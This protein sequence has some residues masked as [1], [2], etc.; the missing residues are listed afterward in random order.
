MAKMSEN[1]KVTGGR[2]EGLK[3]SAVLGFS[4]PPHLNACYSPSSRPDGFNI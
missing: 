3:D 4:L 2:E 1:E